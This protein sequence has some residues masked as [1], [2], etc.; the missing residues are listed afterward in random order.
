MLEINIFRDFS[1]L[2]SLFLIYAP[3]IIVVK[4]FSLLALKWLYCSWDHI[5]KYIFKS[6]EYMQNEKLQSRPGVEINFLSLMFF[7]AH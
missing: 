4:L 3:R 6:G 2:S 7:M 1:K 5:R